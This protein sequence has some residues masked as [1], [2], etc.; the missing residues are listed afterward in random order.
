MGP[1]YFSVVIPTYNRLAMLLR[2]LDALENQVGA[3]EHEVLR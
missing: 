2:V 1:P 3:P